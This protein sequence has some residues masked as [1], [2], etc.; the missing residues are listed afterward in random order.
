[1]LAYGKDHINLEVLLAVRTQ[2]QV[3][4]EEVSHVRTIPPL[5]VI[6]VYICLL[7]DRPWSQEEVSLAWKAR[8][9]DDK[10]PVLILLARDLRQQGKP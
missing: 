5:Q 9:I 1:V 3:R 10:E 8:V 4:K 6:W 2:E 7:Q